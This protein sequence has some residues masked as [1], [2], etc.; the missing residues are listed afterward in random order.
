MEMPNGFE[1]YTSAFQEGWRPDPRLTVSEWADKYRYLGDRAGHAAEKW[2]TDTTPFAR[3]IMD[4]LGPRSPAKR[5]VL[6]KGSQIAGTESGN[7]WLGYIMHQAPGATLVLR[8][9]VEEARRFSRQRL[10]PMI[11]TTPV[12]QTLIHPSRSREGGNTKLMKEFPGGV[13]FLI[14]S[15]SATGVKS[16]PIR[17]LFCDEIDEYPNDVDGQ[18]D[19]IALAEKRLSGP[20][21]NRRKVFLVSTPTI[22]GVSRI[23]SEFLASDQRRYFV[24]CPHCGH[25]DYIR[26]ENIKYDEDDA[27]EVIPE[28]VMLVCVDCG[29][30]IEERHKMQMLPAGEWRPTATGDAE[31]IGFHLSSLYSPLGWLP[32][33]AAAAEFVRAKEDPTRLKTWVNTVLGETWELRGDSVDPDSLLARV[34]RYEADVPTGVGILVASVDV[35]GDRLECAVKGYGASEESWL[36]AYTQFA[37]DPSR[38]EVWLDLDRFLLETFTHESGQQVPISCVTV[39]SGG[40]HTEQVYKFCVARLERRVFAI[41]GGTDRGKP[42]VGRATRNNRYRAPLFVL[43]VDTGKEA[44]YA[45]LRIGSAGPGYCHLP[46]WIDPEY[47]AQLTAE[48]AVRKWKP[49]RGTVREWIKTRSRNEALDLEVYGLAALY[50]LGP[51]VIRSLPERAHALAQPPPEGTDED[52]SPPPAPRRSGWLDGWKG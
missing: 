49:N 34:E 8:P 6:M 51:T 43:C 45:R 39:D 9:T 23:E 12:L 48:K 27:G 21:Y 20:S 10:E 44:V 42:L 3:E 30:L 47:T 14:G 24:P 40:N 50:I 25:Y 29:A 35:Q 7:N 46:D 38:D 2:H 33:A 22:K 11:D 32:W 13:M 17:Y 16:M 4:S 15:N 37:G 41:K 5:V 36:I 1:V 52:T 31:T 26:W 18:G 19:P 28:S